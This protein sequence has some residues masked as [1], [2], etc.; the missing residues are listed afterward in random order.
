MSPARAP[1]QHLVLDAA[2]WLLWA[3]CDPAAAHHNPVARV[4]DARCQLD[5]GYIGNETAL[6]AFAIVHDPRLARDQKLEV[7]LWQNDVLIARARTAASQS[8]PVAAFCQLAA[9]LPP[10]TVRQCLM[11]WLRKPLLPSSPASRALLTALLDAARLP[12]LQLTH[13]RACAPH[14]YYLEGHIAAHRPY[15]E[16]PVVALT[17]SGIVYGSSRF[18]QLS[19]HEFAFVVTFK[20]DIAAQTLHAMC[21]L[22]EDM[23]VSIDPLPGAQATDALIAHLEGKP[24]YQKHRLRQ[25]IG[26]ALLH[27]PGRQPVAS[28]QL[29]ERLE[30]QLTHPVISLSDGEQGLRMHIEQLTPLGTDGVFISGWLHDPQYQLAELELHSALGFSMPM[31]DTLH[32]LPRPDVAQHVGLAHADARPGWIAYVRIAERWRQAVPSL[33]QFHRWHVLVRLRN[34]TTY[35]IHPPLCLLTPMQARDRIIKAYPSEQISDTM[36]QQAISPAATWLQRAVMAHTAI[37]SHHAYGP[38]R[39]TPRYALCI[40]LYERLDFLAVQLANFAQDPD[41]QE[42]EIIYVLDSPWQEAEARARLERLSTLYPLSLQLAV[43]QA[44][45]GYAAASNAAVSLT[46]AEYIVLLNSD[47]F[48]VAPGWLS[49]M[50]AALTQSRTIGLVAP[51]LLYADD[52]LQHAGMYFTQDATPVWLNRHY[53]KGFPRYYPK[54]QHSRAVP[55]LSGACL[56]MARTT[57]QTL[58]GLRTDY[59]IGDFEDSDLCLTANRHGWKSWYCPEAELYHLERQSLPLNGA[60]HGSLAWRINAHRHTAC[61]DGAIREQM[62][63]YGAA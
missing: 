39:Q 24:A 58:G 22:G 23:P 45:S 11:H 61:W 5:S 44:N 62:Q 9:P 50:A 47:V 46:G 52:S 13:G 36:L 35:E 28:A 41:M 25:L 31:R 63:R 19:G 26:Q 4:N 51:K 20:Q 40:P 54:A 33:Q 53:Y 60:Y 56:M 34:G 1:L 15:G 21:Y 3:R 2:H 42:T 8:Q 59:V 37:A 49:T 18:V 6:Y 17:D 38:V 10:D 14:I 7:S 16:P 57:W 12:A 48:P 29:I 43:M 30:W 32:Y 27:A 55:A